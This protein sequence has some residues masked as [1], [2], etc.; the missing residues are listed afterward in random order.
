MEVPTI[1]STGMPSRSSTFRTPIC[2]KPFAPPP[3]STT[4]TF[5]RLDVSM[6][7]A[8]SDDTDVKMQTAA[9]SRSPDFRIIVDMFATHFMP[10]YANIIK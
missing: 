4:A 8:F 3:A 6:S 10:Q 1:M 2:A 5:G 7:C 9:T